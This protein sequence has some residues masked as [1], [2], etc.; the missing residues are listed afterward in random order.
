MFFSARIYSKQ[1]VHIIPG[2]FTKNV[3]NSSEKSKQRISKEFK[4]EKK[5]TYAFFLDIA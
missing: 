4:K 3:L 1:C 5:L 2:R